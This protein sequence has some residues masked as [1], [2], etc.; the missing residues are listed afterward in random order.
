MSPLHWSR[1]KGLVTPPA[2][3]APIQPSVTPSNP[4]YGSGYVS[5]QGHQLLPQWHHSRDGLQFLTAT[6]CLAR[7]HIKPDP[8]VD[9]HPGPASAHPQEV[10][11]CSGLGLTPCPLADLCLAAGWNGPWLPRSIP[12]RTADAPKSWLMGSCQPGG[13]L[14]KR[15]NAVSL[16]LSVVYW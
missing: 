7:G 16:I 11:W 8:P 4:D 1:G 2:L 6:P 5:L 15:P 9:K 12:W 3:A 13:D 14:T 10:P